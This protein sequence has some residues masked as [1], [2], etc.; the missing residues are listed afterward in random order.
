[1]KRLS[2]YDKAVLKYCLGAVLAAVLTSIIYVIVVNG[3]IAD[4]TT[5]GLVILGFAFVQFCLQLLYFLHITEGGK[6][7]WRLH[8]LWFV[9]LTVAIIVVGS[10]WIMKNLDYNMGM[11]PEQ[12]QKRMLE[13]AQKGF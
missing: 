3:V 6:P 12:M 7:N 1:M 10:I 4:A 11:S 13:E 5:L 2:T 8:S 9:V